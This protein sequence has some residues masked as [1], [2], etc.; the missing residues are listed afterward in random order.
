MFICRNTPEELASLI[1]QAE[2]EAQV[3]RNQERGANILQTLKK[4][5]G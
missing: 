2:D 4:N 3:R 1:K 5:V